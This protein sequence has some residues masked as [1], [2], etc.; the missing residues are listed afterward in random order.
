MQTV[1]YKPLIQVLYSMGLHGLIHRKR[2]CPY[3]VLHEMQLICEP[4]AANGYL[5]KCTHCF[6]TMSVSKCTILQNLNVRRFD[7]SLTL[8][9]MNCRTVTTAR[10]VSE[11]V[12][13]IT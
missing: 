3:C 7:A 2:K 8:W 9:M 1:L 11:R 5:W 12:R 4:D 6:E 13:F 10:I